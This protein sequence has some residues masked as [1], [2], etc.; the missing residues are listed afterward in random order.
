MTANTVPFV[1]GIKASSE[2]P[3]PRKK[4]QKRFVTW[5]EQG[6]K[7]FLL[8]AGEAYPQE[9]LDYIF[10]SIATIYGIREG[11]GEIRRVNVN[12]A[13]LT[14]EE[15]RELKATKIGTYQ[16]FQETYHFPTYQTD[17]SARS[18]GGLPLEAKC[19]WQSF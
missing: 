12:I 14:V 16:L 7:E 15:F 19:H 6:T 9:G 17:A 2:E 18:E 4:L 13:P 5:S 11:K 10:K 3:S 8:V 1:C